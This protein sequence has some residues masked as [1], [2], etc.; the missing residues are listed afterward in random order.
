MEGGATARRALRLLEALAASGPHPTLDELAGSVGLTKST[1][2]RLLRVLQDESYVERAEGGGYRLGSR[3][4]ALAAA[5]LPQMDLYAAVRPV[6]RRLA[7]ASGETATLHRRAGDLAI[8]VLA[9]EAE[10]HSLRR[11]ASIGE[12]VPLYRGCA[13]LAIMASLPRDQ[14]QAIMTRSTVAADQPALWARIEGIRRRGAVS[15]QGENHPGI[16][17][18]G[19]PVAATAGLAS[20]TSVV[21]SG[22]DARWTP[23][24]MDEFTPQLQTAETELSL[25]FEQESATALLLTGPRP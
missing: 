16:N 25:L 22:P 19:V 14:Q 7:H 1:A 6:L 13:G 20:A 17:G 21:V 10:L 9:A 18:V 4:V 2:Y 5:A 8:L 15:S 23:A 11:V 24:R 3:L 12:A